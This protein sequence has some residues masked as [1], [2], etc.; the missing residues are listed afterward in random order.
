[1]AKVIGKG[2]GYVK[3]GYKKIASP[4]AEANTSPEPNDGSNPN[5]RQTGERGDKATNRPGDAVNPGKEKM[6]QDNRRT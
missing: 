3:G 2:Y 1:M 5:S 6:F 4:G